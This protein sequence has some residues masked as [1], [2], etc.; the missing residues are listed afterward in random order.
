[1]CTPSPKSFSILALV[2]A[3][4]VVPCAPVIVYLYKLITLHFSGLK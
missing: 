1:M 4:S 2:L 3:I